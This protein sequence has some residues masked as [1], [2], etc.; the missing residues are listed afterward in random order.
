MLIHCCF[1]GLTQDLVSHGFMIPHSYVVKWKAPLSMSLPPIFLGLTELSVLFSMA[2]GYH[3]F[4]GAW[5]SENWLL[6]SILEWWGR[7]LQ[8]MFT[9]CP[10]VRL[11][12]Y[13]ADTWRGTKPSPSLRPNLSLVPVS[14]SDPVSPQTRGP[15]R[16]V[17]ARPSFSW[18]KSDN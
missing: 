13:I 9:M 11:R 17:G 18:M 8:Y 2:T 3:C 7:E 12:E 16:K 1:P 15:E 6:C 5:L 10:L 14:L 4:A